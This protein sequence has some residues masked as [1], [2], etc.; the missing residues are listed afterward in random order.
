MN[1]FDVVKNFASRK[2]NK[3]TGDVSW[4]G[5]RVFSRDETLYSFGRHF[6][7]AKYLGHKEGKGFFL[8]NGDKYSTST[9]QHQ[10]MVQQKC[11]G[12][13]TV[14][15]SAL[16]SAGVNAHSLR[17]ENVV[18]YIEDYRSGS[19]VRNKESGKF[20][21]KEWG[22]EAYQYT[23]FEKPR[24]G[25]F[26]PH[27]CQSN[28]D[29]TEGYWHTLGA[30]LIESGGFQYLCSLDEG[31]YFVSK[32]RHKVKS[33]ARSFEM[34]KPRKVREVEKEGVNVTR[35]G[36]W[37]FIPTSNSPSDLAKKTGL[38]KTK[39]VKLA[40]ASALPRENSDSNLHVV[41]HLKLKGKTYAWGSVYHRDPFTKRASGE[42]RTITL[43][44]LVHEVYKNTEL[45]SWSMSGNV[46]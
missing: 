14:S 1:H 39:L 3:H 6:I 15:F 35:Q 40:K 18:D 23:P 2:V 13:P 20:F 17:M 41:K 26:I 16:Q 46:D 22:E 21:E 43:G 44:D 27:L 5:S 28:D 9:S 10:G 8:K 38:S 12:G 25:M 29:L 33:V 30:C 4:K 24:A 42:H 45:A 36:E 31:R 19:I 34:L 32:L 11:K 7:L 37:F